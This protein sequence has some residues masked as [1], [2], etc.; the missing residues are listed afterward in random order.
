M[1]QRA[2]VNWSLP[3]KG[4][5]STE[6]AMLAVLM[7]IRHELQVIRSELSVILNVATCGN[8]RKAALAVQRLDKR[9]AKRFPAR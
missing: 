8:T 1:R 3:E 5:V 9:L 4:P 6:R 7:D 2:N